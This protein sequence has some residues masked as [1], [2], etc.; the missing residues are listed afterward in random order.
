MLFSRFDFL[1]FELKTKTHHPCFKCCSEDKGQVLYLHIKMVTII[2]LCIPF[3]KLTFQCPP[4]LLCSPLLLDILVSF[5]FTG[6]EHCFGPNDCTLHPLSL[7]TGKIIN[8][9]EVS[10]KREEFCHEL[11]QSVSMSRGGRT[12]TWHILCIS[13]HFLECTFWAHNLY[14]RGCKGI[15]NFYSSGLHP[16]MWCWKAATCSEIM[17]VVSKR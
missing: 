1:S 5:P 16:A 9:K 2:S 10:Y 7:D 17:K 11:R 13:K 14:D 15:F 4:Y 6:Y 3:K 8:G 12:F